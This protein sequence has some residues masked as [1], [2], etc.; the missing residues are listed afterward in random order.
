[1][2]VL[3][4]GWQAG[5]HGINRDHCVNCFVIGKDRLGL[6]GGALYK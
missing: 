3:V 1:V 2:D 6:D 5:D 4:T